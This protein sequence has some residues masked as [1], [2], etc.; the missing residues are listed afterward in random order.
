VKITER[1]SI[2]VIEKLREVIF[3]EDIIL[4]YRNKV[5]DF[6]RNRKQPFGQMLLFMFNLVKKSLAIEIDNFVAFL[7]SRLDSSQIKDFR[8]IHLA[9]Y[10]N[11][12][13]NKC[14]RV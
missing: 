2:C 4:K 3:S 11:I 1:N 10:Y 8:P 13:V 14:F 12:P 9:T 5:S 6:T 7:N